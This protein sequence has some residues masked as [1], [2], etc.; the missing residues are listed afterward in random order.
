MK[1][2]T[3]GKVCHLWNINILC[4]VSCIL[5]EFGVFLFLISRAKKV[6][7]CFYSIINTINNTVNYALKNALNSITNTTKDFFNSIPNFF[8]I[9]SENTLKELNDTAEYIS[10]TTNNS[11][12]AFQ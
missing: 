6:L 5:G 9:T 3:L 12:N 1:H 2:S 4:F 11:Y 10:D 7:D 8:P